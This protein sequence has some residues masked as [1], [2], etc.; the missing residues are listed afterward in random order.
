MRPFFSRASL[1]LFLAVLFLVLQGCLP[2]ASPNVPDPGAVTVEGALGSPV[3]LANGDSTVYAR[4]RIG[5]ARRPDSE[6]GPVNLCL[7]ID[8][9]GSM[10]GEAIVEARTAAL[11]ML[12]AL[13][14]GDRLAI[15]VFHSKAEILLP[16]TVIDAAVRAD[17]RKKIGAIEAR[18]TTDMGN[19]LQLAI[20]QVQANLNPKGLNRV[21]LLGDGI[22]NNGSSIDYSARRAGGL[23]IAVTTLGLGLD[24]DE[25][26]MGKIAD[27]SGGRYQYIESPDKLAGFFR[28]ELQRINTV[29]GRQAQAVITPGP[30]VKIEAVVGTD[31][32]PSGGAVHVPLGDITRGDGRDILVRMTVT[33]RKAGVPIELLDT[34]ISFEDALDGAG[35]LERRVYLG[36]HTTLDEAAIA[37]AKNPEVELS[38]ALAEA[39]A[40]TIR[41]L[42][43]SKQGENMRAREMLTKGSAAALAQTKRTPSSELEKHAS[44]MSA[45]AKDM[46]ELDAP[47]QAKR[48][49][50]SGYDF[51]DDALQSAP[52]AEMPAPTPAAVRRQKEAHQK[53][54]ETIR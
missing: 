15:V 11:Q 52:A 21:V 47:R 13:K 10:E 36:A 5:T 7:S 19:G 24:Y 27:L 51:S 14:D 3:L 33:P 40:T 42:E 30:G 53:A 54:F 6:R 8:T 9:S 4:I 17:A 35:H 25:T 31:V 23:G 50:E 1:P 29:Y 26:L 46:P 43:L 20:D 18:G 34:V 41:A 48:S 45:V 2:A 12:D 37:K 38:A 22:P 16:S 39:S 44:N 49:A 32:S 28:D